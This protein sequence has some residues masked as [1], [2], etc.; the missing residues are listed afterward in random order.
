MIFRGDSAK[1]KAMKEEISHL[2][3]RDQ[4]RERTL[5]SMSVSIIARAKELDRMVEEM[6]EVRR[7]SNG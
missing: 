2:E 3:R 4:E 6:K 1:T 7:G 5:S